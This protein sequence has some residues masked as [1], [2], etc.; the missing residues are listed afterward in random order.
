MERRSAWIE[1]TRQIVQPEPDEFTPPPELVDNVDIRRDYGTRGLQI[2]VKLANIH[3]TPESPSYEG[4]AWHV[5][6]QLVG[7]LWFLSS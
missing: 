6:G 1:E 7:Q 3:L 5:E 4:G 2:I